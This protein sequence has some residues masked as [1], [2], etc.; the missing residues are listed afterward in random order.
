MCLKDRFSDSRTRGVKNLLILCVY[1]A[2]ETSKKRKNLVGYIDYR[3]IDA[4]KNKYSV[5]Y[6]SIVGEYF[7][8]HL[9][10]W[11]VHTRGFLISKMFGY[12]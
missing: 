2:D 7:S 10:A 3:S 12:F 6:Y 5:L 9:Y 1:S 4:R 11:L 8:K